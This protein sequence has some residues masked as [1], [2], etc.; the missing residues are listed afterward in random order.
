MKNPLKSAL[1]KIIESCGYRIF[2]KDRFYENFVPYNRY[3]TDFIHYLRHFVEIDKVNVCIDVGANRGQTA[4][5]FSNAFPSAEIFSCEPVSSTYALL[6][7]NTAELG[8][9]K[10]FNLALGSKSGSAVINL[11]NDDQLNS[12]VSD[13]SSGETKAGRQETI[14]VKTLDAMMVEEGIQHVNLLKTDTEGFD[15]E[16]LRGASSALAQKR[17]D[18]VYCEVAFNPDDRLHTYFDTVS[19]FLAEY[20]FVFLGLFDTVYCDNPTQLFHANALFGR[21]HASIITPWRD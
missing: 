19:R 13:S 9:V 18:L 15:L 10:T 20:D 14:K 16:V 6:V 4:R 1:R 5:Y 2:P 21:K 3:G 17:V 7:K 8:R 12:L 11:A